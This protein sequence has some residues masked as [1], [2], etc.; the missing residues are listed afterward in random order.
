[1]RLKRLEAEVRE[2]REQEAD[3]AAAA[4]VKLERGQ[5]VTKAEAAAYLGFS[6]KTL[7]RREREGKIR[8]CPGYGALVFF[9][10]RDVL[11]LASAR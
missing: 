11:R 9:A 5:P 1:M 10:A 4:S 7:E 8:R 3:L 6:P 2:S